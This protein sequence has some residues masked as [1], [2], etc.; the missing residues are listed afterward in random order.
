MQVGQRIQTIDSGILGNVA[1][2]SRNLLVIADDGRRLVF[3][4]SEVIAI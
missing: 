2:V 1:Q 4:E 3:H